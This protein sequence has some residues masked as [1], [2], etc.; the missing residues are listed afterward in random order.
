MS[1]KTKGMCEGRNFQSKT[2]H[3]GRGFSLVELVVV[4]VLMAIL[5]SMATVSIRGVIIRQRLARAAEVVE[6]FDTALRRSARNG[7]RR[8]VGV[9]DRSR[10]R[11]VI[12]QV[13]GKARTFSLPK[14]VSID[15]V[16]LGSV[17]LGQSPSTSSET[18]ITAAGDGSSASYA[19]RLVSG[20][21][22]RW[23]LLAGGTGQVIH[24][25][26]STS[27]DSLLGS[28]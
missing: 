19:V 24:D 16:R 25:L 3:Q 26:D 7:R 28:R 10:R 17:R 1:G 5:A 21:T 15:S 4:L 18:Q 14:Q 11:L 23:V 8:V 22:R 27:V 6:Q 13:N 2:S 9:I 20:Q 12:G